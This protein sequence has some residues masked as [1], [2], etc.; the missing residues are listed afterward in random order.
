MQ[1]SAADPADPVDRRRRALLCA[2]AGGLLAPLGPPA[3]AAVP[4]DPAGDPSVLP[5]SLHGLIASAGLPLSAIGLQVQ[6]VGAPAAPL[7]SLNAGSHFQLASTTKA[8]TALAA[9]SLLG[10]GYRWQT[11][12]FLT[13]PLHQ[14]RLLG[15]LVIV[16]GGNALLRTNDLLDWFAQMRSQGLNEVW[17]DIVLDRDAFHLSD[18]DHAGTPPPAV[19]RPHHAWPDALTLDEGRLRVTVQAGARGRALV[20]LNPPLAGVQVDNGLTAAAGCA[21][22]ARWLPPAAGTESPR[23]ALQGQWTARCGELETALAPLAHP[24]FTRRAVASLWRQAGGRLRGRVR[25]HVEGRLDDA[26]GAGL[27]AI[28]QGRADAPSS[29]SAATAGVQDGGERAAPWAV[30]QSAALPQLIRDINKTS[31]NLAARCLML[32]LAPGFPQR[33]ATLANARGRLQ[34]WLQQGG[35]APGDIVV[36]NGSGLSRGERGKPQSMVRLLRQ[37]WGSR[38]GQDFVDSL[39]VAGIDGT[40]SHRMTRGPATGRAFLKTGSLLDTRALAGYVQGRSGVTYAVAMLVNHPQA[41][42]ATPM[43]DALVEWIAG[44]A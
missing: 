26:A 2:G 35:L 42:R 40:L 33:S 32:S 14:G 23:L 36:D 37:S 5:A 30:H 44:R 18:A 39:P 13:G 27:A 22:S 29:A 21:L 12:A 8:V 34:G 43:L 7:L 6:A 38:Q 20:Q 1:D 9:L 41:Q 3:V 24:E 16:G 10:S 11:R 19:D 31:D 15:D 17:G 4:R 25:A 28:M